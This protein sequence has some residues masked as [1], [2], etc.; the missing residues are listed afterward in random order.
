MLEIDA[1]RKRAERQMALVYEVFPS[2]DGLVRKV[3]IKTPKGLYER[4]IAKVCLI[5]TRRELE[6]G[7]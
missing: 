7:Q 4:P 3:K 6:N 1:N 2:S 5:A